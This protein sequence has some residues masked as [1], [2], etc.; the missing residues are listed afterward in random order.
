VAFKDGS[1]T[2]GS[3]SLDASGLAT[4]STSGLAV[5]PHSITAVYAGDATFSGSTSIALTETVNQAGTST[6][7]SSNL[8]PSGYGQSVTFTAN[9]TPLT[10]TGTVQFFDGANALGTA[11]VSAGKASLSTSTLSAGSHSITARYSGDNNYLGSVSPAVSQSVSQAGTATALTSSSSTSVYGQSVTFTATVSPSAGTAKPAGTVTFL[12]GVTPLGS[13]SLNANGVA[14][15]SISSLS[16]GSHSITAQYS[17]NSN[18]NASTSAVLTQTVNK[19]GTTT[20]LTSSQNPSNTAQPVTFT[21]TVSSTTAT[22]TVQF[23]DGSTKLGG[24]VSLSGGK[25]TFSTSALTPGKHSITA[26]YS[27]DTNYNSSTSAVLTQ[28]VRRKN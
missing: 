15:F 7:L 9:I 25:A 23:F 8:N 24:P 5:G 4:F 1:T 16:V 19:A 18:F 28:T 13:T 22:G 12:D 10:A 14:T 20:T 3:S 11:S 2:L 26:S 27:G 17:G 21:A 6:T